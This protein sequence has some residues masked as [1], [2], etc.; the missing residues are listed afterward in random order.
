MH[1][2]KV[3]SFPQDQW[4]RVASDVVRIIIQKKNTSLEYLVTYRIYGDAAPLANES[5]AAWEDNQIDVRSKRRLDI[6]IKA[7]STVAEANG[8]VE[9]FL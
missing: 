9:I 1:I 6:Y 8:E 2:P 7:K 5:G 3:V 4:T